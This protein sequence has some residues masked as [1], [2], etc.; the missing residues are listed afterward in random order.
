MLPKRK[1]TPK[2][3]NNIGSHHVP[4]RKTP[5]IRRGS[6][7]SR[8]IKTKP[9]TSNAKPINRNLAFIGVP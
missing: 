7:N 9:N 2:T 3:S 6:K 1:P 5:Y 8:Y 4:L